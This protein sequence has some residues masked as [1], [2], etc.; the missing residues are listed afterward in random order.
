[1]LLILTAMILHTYIALFFFL[2]YLNTGKKN[3]GEMSSLVAHQAWL[4]L[5]CSGP[6]EMA[7]KDATI[8]SEEGKGAVQTCA[9]WRAPWLRVLLKCSHI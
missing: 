5:F 3:K 4:S 7:H 6:S 1:M 9:G 8:V 2:E